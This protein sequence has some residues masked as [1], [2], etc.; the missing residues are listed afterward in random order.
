M[1]KKPSEALRLLNWVT[2]PCNSH[3]PGG[4]GDVSVRQL[5]GYAVILCHKGSSY[6]RNKWN[7]SVAV[8]SVSDVAFGQL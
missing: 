1:G 4:L 8:S 5:Y 7:N 3:V 6:E 2:P